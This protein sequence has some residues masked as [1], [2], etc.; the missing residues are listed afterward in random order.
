M[1]RKSRHF[2]LCSCSQLLVLGVTLVSVSMH[3]SDFQDLPLPSSQVLHPSTISFLFGGS[4]SCPFSHY[5]SR[6]IPL[7]FSPCFTKVYSQPGLVAASKQQFS[8]AHTYPHIH[9]HTYGQLSA[10][11]P[12]HLQFKSFLPKKKSTF[13]FIMNSSCICCLVFN[14]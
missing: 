1:G 6:D 14:F 8:L 10:C 7:L 3:P 11:P 5:R 2:A 4:V 13:G 12:Q 9:T